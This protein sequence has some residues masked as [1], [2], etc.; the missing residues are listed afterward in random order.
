M[1]QGTHNTTCTRFTAEGRTAEATNSQNHGTR[2]GT[3]SAMGMPE[4][5]TVH[6]RQFTC[7]CC[8]VIVWGSRR[9]HATSTAPPS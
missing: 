4:V 7:T 8:G 9:L 3:L 2:H 5:H 1:Q 6:T